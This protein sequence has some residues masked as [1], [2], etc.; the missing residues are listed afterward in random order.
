MCLCDGSKSVEYSQKTMEEAVKKVEK[1][2]ADLG[3]TEILMPLEHIYRQP[4]IPNH[5]RQVM[6]K[7]THPHIQV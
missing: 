7:G 2:E 6:H 1:M 4:C 3:G 5:P